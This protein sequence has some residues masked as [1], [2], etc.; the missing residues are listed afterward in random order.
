MRD[1]EEG[2]ALLGEGRWTKPREGTSAA[3][4]QRAK[5]GEQPKPIKVSKVCCAHCGV[6]KEALQQCS[7]CKVALFCGRECFAAAWPEHKKTCRK[8]KNKKKLS[9]GT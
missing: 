1:V 7:R 3:P 9:G 5:G 2:T 4:A 8:K 6:C